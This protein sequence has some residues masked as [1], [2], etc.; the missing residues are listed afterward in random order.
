MAA[1]RWNQTEAAAG[2]RISDR[3]LRR[4]VTDRVLT[5]DDAGKFDPIPTLQ[6]FITYLQRDEQ[7]KAARRELLLIDA[8]RK[9]LALRR[10]LGEMV[11]AT[12]RAER[13]ADLWSAV[14]SVWAVAAASF[15]YEV[16][17]IP[18]L[19]DLDALAIANRAD[20]AGKSELIA[21]RKLWEQ[22]LKDQRVQLRDDGRI[23]RLLSD[24]ASEHG[25]LTAP[26]DDAD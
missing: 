24:L 7:H 18:S 15:Y 4:L 20:Q 12:E 23:E 8:Q 2:L 25:E 14:W 17:S 19:P 11:T 13:D 9:R 3:H 10:S 6:T 22:S 5:P 21:M 26:A 16:R 1:R